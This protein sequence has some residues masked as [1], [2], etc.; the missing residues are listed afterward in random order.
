MS[1]GHEEK[2]AVLIA[3]IQVN[4]TGNPAAVWSYRPRGPML[5]RYW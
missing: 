2:L 3:D 4:L 1:P 5:G